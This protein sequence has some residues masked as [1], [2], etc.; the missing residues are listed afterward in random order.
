MDLG[1]LAIMAVIY[2]VPVIVVLF[3]LYKLYQFFTRGR[4]VGFASMPKLTTITTKNLPKPLVTHLEAINEKAEK[5]LNYY[6]NKQIADEAVMGESQFLVKKILNEDL[7][8][9]IADYQ[10]LDNTR[11]NQMA[12]GN[13]GKTAYQLLLDY[14]TTINEQFDTMLDAMYEQNAQKLLVSNRYLQARFGQQNNELNLL[15]DASRQPD[16]VI[17]PPMIQSQDVKIGVNIDKR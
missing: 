10:R 16:S 11:A 3:V 12:V 7:P 1:W 9:A 13:T 17:P 2:I 8:E 14:L 15:V 4:V 6:N 5:L